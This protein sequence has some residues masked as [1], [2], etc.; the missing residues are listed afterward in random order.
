MIGL[1]APVTVLF[2]CYCYNDYEEWDGWDMQKAREKDLDTERS[3]I[4]LWESLLVTSDKDLE[5]RTAL[6]PWLILG[7]GNNAS[8]AAYI[9]G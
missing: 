6:V 2:T 3:W 9:V 5:E 4:E 8:S 1:H 7:S